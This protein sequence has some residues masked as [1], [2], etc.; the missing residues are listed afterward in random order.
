VTAIELIEDVFGRNL[1]DLV[2]QPV[3]TRAIVRSRRTS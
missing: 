3:P 1:L 2:G